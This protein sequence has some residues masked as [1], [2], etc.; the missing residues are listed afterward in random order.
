MKNDHSFSLFYFSRQF[1]LLHMQ[2]YAQMTDDE[3]DEAIQHS[4]G[5]NA[6]IGANAVRARL[7]VGVRIQRRRVRESLVRVN[8][9][10]AA[11]RALSHR[12]HRRT[13]SVAGPNTL[14]HID[15]NHKLIRQ[16]KNIYMAPEHTTH[17]SCYT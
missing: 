3:L 17:E 12:L 15:G 6:H 11:H 4:V 1:N 8:P 5:E 16:I 10:G 9:A 14:W 7:F 2:Q 13:Y